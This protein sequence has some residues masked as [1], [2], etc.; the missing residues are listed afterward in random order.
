MKSIIAC[1]LLLC[2]TVLSTEAQSTKRA[3]VT[4]KTTIHC[5]HC[6]Q[7]KSC[8]QRIND[9]I[10]DENKGIR[11]VKIDSEKQEI[12]VY[13]NTNRTNEQSIQ[14]AILAAGFSANDKQP[15]AAAIE[16]LDGCCKKK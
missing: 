15:T 14:E 7:C 1:L 16:Q 6:L 3:A 8:G 9:K 12:T 4:F 5:D 13:Y 2:S 11:K 10:R